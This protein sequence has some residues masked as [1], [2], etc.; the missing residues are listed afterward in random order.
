MSSFMPEEAM[1]LWPDGR[2]PVYD[3]Y[4]TVNH[5]GAVYIGHYM[6]QVRAPPSNKRGEESALDMNLS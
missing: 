5:Y 2:Q 4:A 3:L 6:A 1:T